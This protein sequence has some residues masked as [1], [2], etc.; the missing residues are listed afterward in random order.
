ME[1]QGSRAQLTRE[2]QRAHTYDTRA[3]GICDSEAVSSSGLLYT[4]SLGACFGALAAGTLRMAHSWRLGAPPGPGPA[5]PLLLLRQV[6][7]AR[8]RP[9][10]R[11]ARNR[12]NTALGNRLRGPG[13]APRR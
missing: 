11:A 5:K 4:R 1:A 10:G 8:A 9:A 12:D 2:Q 3:F 6:G 7:R 13:S